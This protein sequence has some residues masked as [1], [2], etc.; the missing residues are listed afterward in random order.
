VSTS[1]QSFALADEND[2]EVICGNLSEASGIDNVDAFLAREPKVH[3]K[4]NDGF[5]IQAN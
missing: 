5:L 3:I 4:L 2:K 1:S